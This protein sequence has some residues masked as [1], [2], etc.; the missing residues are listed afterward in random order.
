[1]RTTGEKWAPAD[2]YDGLYEVSNLGRVKRSARGSR[3]YIGK[4]IKPHD[5]HGY[6]RV[7]LYKNGLSKNVRVHKIVAVAFI[8]KCPSGKEINHIDGCKDNNSVSNL[9]Y[10]SRSENELHAI[11]LGLLKVT[12]GSEKGN[13]ILSE[14]DVLAIRS[15]LFSG[16]TQQAIAEMFGTSRPNISSI[17]NRRSW[18]WL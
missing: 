12:R 8:G 4:I 3:T 16:A 5:C 7:C 10:I 11:R 13:S 15:A 17:A 2:G 18:A 1:M 9:E 14:N 6:K